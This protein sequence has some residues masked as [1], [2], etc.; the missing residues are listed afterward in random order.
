MNQQQLTEELVLV[1]GRLVSYRSQLRARDT[2]LAIRTLGRN[3]SQ[4]E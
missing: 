2:R 4:I 3:R 1:S